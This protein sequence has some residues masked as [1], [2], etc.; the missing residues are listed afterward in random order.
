[1]S[2]AAWIDRANAESIALVGKPQCDEAWNGIA[3]FARQGE[4]IIDAYWYMPELAAQY[5]TGMY[6]PIDRG[7]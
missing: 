6:R 2:V 7:W 5:V 4:R 3:P 1:M